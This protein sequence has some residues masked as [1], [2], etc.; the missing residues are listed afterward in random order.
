MRQAINWTDA[1]QIHW[2]IYAALGLDELLT[3]CPRALDLALQDMN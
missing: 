3:L 2:G 1:D